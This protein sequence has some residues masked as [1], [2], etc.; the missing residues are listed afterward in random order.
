MYTFIPCGQDSKLRHSSPSLSQHQQTG[1]RLF[2]IIFISIDYTTYVAIMLRLLR[3]CFCKNPND[4]SRLL[5]YL[6][7]DDYCTYGTAIISL[8]LF[9]L[10]YIDYCYYH[11]IICIIIIANYYFYYSIWHVLLLLF[12][13]QQLCALYALSQYYLNYCFVLL[14]CWLLL[15]NAI[16][17]IIVFPKY[18]GNYGNKDNCNNTYN[19]YNSYNLCI[20]PTHIKVVYCFRFCV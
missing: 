11:T 15:S 10:Y 6:K 2:R 16:I 17:C 4:Y 8:I 12:F 13:P 20:P 3:L 9:G 18:Y 14:L 19:W 1:V 5:H 7:K